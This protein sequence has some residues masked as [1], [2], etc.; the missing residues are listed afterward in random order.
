[1]RRLFAGRKP[2]EVVTLMPDARALKD[3]LLAAFNAHDLDRVLQCHS[4]DGVLVTPSGVA[5]GH[6]Q[7]AS[8]YEEVFKGSPTCA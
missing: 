1:M 8:F 5:E 7:I 3:K 6:D 4:R 2:Q